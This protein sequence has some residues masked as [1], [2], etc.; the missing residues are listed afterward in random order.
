[1]LDVRPGITDPASIKFRNENELM[2]QAE[3][4]EKY[5]IEVIMQ[6]KIKL[7][8][9]YVDTHEFVEFINNNRVMTN[10]EIDRL[11]QRIGQGNNVSKDDLEMLQE[12]RKTFQEPISHVFDFV[13]KA[14]RKIDKQC[15]V[16]YRIKRIDTIIEKLRRFKNNNNGPMSFSRMWDIAGCRCIFNG[17]SEKRIYQLRDMIQ[18]EY[19]M[20]CKINDYVANPRPSGYRSLHIYV[21]DKE[22]QKPVEIQIRNTKHHNWATLVEIVDLLY[23]TKNKEQQSSGRLGRFLYLYSNATSLL[24]KEFSEMLKIERKM[25]V[26]E[27]MSNVLTRNYLQIRKQ[28][29]KQKQIGNFFV[30]T[31][32]RKYSE[33]LSFPSFLEAEK[34]YYEKYLDNKDSNIVLTHLNSPDF[35][36]ISM[37][38]SNYMLAMHAFF[39]DYR[40]M[41][42]NQIINCV[43]NNNYYR[44]F[45]DFRIYNSNIKCHFNN[46]RQEVEGIENCLSDPAI[47]KNQVNKWAREIQNRFN[48]W[49][50]ETLAFV[51]ILGTE[52]RG[53]EF[54]QLILRSRIKRM[55]KAMS[56]K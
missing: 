49:Q 32:N 55:A 21:K 19:G 50:Q 20:Q 31:A 52:A 36:Q 24:E 25:K 43:R 9:E 46:L 56:G 39:D 54:K 34:A 1:M 11:G 41:V 45:K 48:S 15:I 14:A 13:L 30:I 35:N 51:R 17:T 12:Y 2:E 7:Y 26:F 16:T 29:I 33:I 22:T 23:E 28:W 47:G 53:D 8:L 42:A 44:I 5:Y 3:D 6:E 40:V 10:G 4:P 37:A 27:R 38:Y 18:Q